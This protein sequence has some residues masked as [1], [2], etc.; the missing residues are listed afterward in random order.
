[1]LAI[2]TRPTAERPTCQS[3]LRGCGREQPPS[4]LRGQLRHRPR[5]HALRAQSRFRHAPWARLC[6][7]LPADWPVF[8][9]RETQ[10]V[11]RG[12]RLSPAIIASIVPAASA[13]RI[14]SPDT[15]ELLGIPLVEHFPTS[16]AILGRI[17]RDRDVFGDGPDLGRSVESSDRNER[18]RCDADS[19]GSHLVILGSSECADCPT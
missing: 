2:R 12:S 9:Q 1:M 10:G 8:R 5:I 7:R 15:L 13:R 14:T 19:A 6:G 16:G 17:E 4:Q 11:S 3:C 18:D